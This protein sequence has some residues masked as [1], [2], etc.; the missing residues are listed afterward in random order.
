MPR[1]TS[2]RGKRIHFVSE[3]RTTLQNCSLCVKREQ[4]LFGQGGVLFNKTASAA[5]DIFDVPDLH[6]VDALNAFGLFARLAPD[7]AID[8][9]GL[10][11]LVQAPELEHNGS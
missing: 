2:L 10:R 4:T 5:R 3:L 6:S 1:I 8:D 9:L 7:P 11:H